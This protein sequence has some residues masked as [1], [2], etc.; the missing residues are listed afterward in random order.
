[1]ASIID[2]FKKSTPK[3]AKANTRGVDKTPIGVEFPSAGSKDLMKSDL[4]KYRNGQ[5]GDRAAGNTPNKKYSD[6]VKK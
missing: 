4:S 5:L 2:T 1:M 6:T 3:T